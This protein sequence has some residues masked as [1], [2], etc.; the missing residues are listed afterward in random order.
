M[1]EPTPY[2]HVD[3]T[4]R[5]TVTGELKAAKYRGLPRW[6]AVLAALALILSVAA[7]VLSLIATAQPAS[8]A[9]GDPLEGIDP[10][11]PGTFAALPASC[12][13]EVPGKCVIRSAG[14]DRPIVVLWGDSHAVQQVP[15]IAGHAV[16]ANRNFVAFTMGLCPPFIP[17]ASDLS[18]CAQNAR[19][20]LAYIRQKDAAGKAVTVVLG[21]FWHYYWTTTDGPR[22]GRAAAFRAGEAPMF[23]A[24]DAL[25]VRVAGI[26]QAPFIP[27]EEGSTCTLE[28]ETCLRTTMVPDEGAITSWLSSRL[29]TIRRHYTAEVLPYL[30]DT[31]AC[32]VNV[33]EVELFFD[34]VHLNVAL[35]YRHSPAFAWVV[36]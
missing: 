6:P 25:D 15:A 8:G 20:A 16:N 30:C 17:A 21:G 22:A 26:G 14:N 33:G 2:A 13:P 19:A 5:V 1:T 35:T 18:A 32:Y 7:L 9:D 31:V 12:N 27:L 11:N 34:A 4:G 23:A 29:N 10:N 3:P 28:S 24:L 36:A